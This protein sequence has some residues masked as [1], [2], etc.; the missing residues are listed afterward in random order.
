[1]HYSAYTKNINTNG[2]HSHFTHFQ[3]VQGIQWFLARLSMPAWSW[4]GA[5]NKASFPASCL[6]W[7]QTSADLLKGVLQSEIP[8]LN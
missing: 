4:D 3:L 5:A 2:I 8:L 6:S 1:M 7:L